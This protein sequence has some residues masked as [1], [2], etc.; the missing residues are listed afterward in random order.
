MPCAGAEDPALH[1]RAGWS[2][3]RFR[4][5]IPPD[6]AQITQFYVTQHDICKTLAERA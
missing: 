6:Q 1:Q 4:W 2:G 5:V 3:G